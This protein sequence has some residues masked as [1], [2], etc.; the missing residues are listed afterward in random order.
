MLCFANGFVADLL[1]V[2]VFVNGE[3]VPGTVC[4]WDIID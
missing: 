1:S 2:V 3:L 4:V